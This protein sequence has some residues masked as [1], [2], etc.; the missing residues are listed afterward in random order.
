MIDILNDFMELENED[1]DVDQEAMG[2]SQYIDDLFMQRETEL[3]PI[4]TKFSFLN[5]LVKL[6]HLK[7]SN[8]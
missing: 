2:S 1:D 6:M 5:F 7:I 4:C 3:Y 8:K